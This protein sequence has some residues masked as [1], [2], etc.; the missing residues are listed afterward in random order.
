MLIA[1]LSATIG[2]IGLKPEEVQGPLGIL[3]NTL[4]TS[5][6]PLVLTTTETVERTAPIGSPKPL[7]F[8]Y[9]CAPQV[10]FGHKATFS[11][12]WPCT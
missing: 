2:L 6:D 1:H 9:L 5:Q 12:R 10:E 11:P 3:V 7:T 8:R 4:T